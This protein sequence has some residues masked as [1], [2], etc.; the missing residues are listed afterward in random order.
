M[1]PLL[2]PRFEEAIHYAIGVHADHIRKGSGVP[3]VAH[4]LG[5]T[6]LVLEDHGDED[7]AIAALLHDAVEDGDGRAE[8]EAIRAQ[9]GE[10]SRRSSRA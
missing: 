6:A 1:T 9:F 5:V 7:E 2:G 3:Y 8:L 4:V 10:R